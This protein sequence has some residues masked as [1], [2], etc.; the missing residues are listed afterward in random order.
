MQIHTIKIFMPHD[1]KHKHVSHK[2]QITQHASNMKTYY[3]IPPNTHEASYYPHTH[4]RSQ[5]LNNS[6][7]FQNTDYDHTIQPIHLHVRDI[8]PNP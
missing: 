8:P 6:T 5:I 7:I 3:L 2:P 4:N 1:Y